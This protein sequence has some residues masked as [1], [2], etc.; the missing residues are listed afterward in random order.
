MSTLPDE[1]F[2]RLAL[3]A[4]HEAARQGSTAVAA[5]IAR[6]DEVLAVAGAAQSRTGNPTRHAEL[7][8]IDQACARVGREALVGAT[9]YSTMEP[10]P[11]CAWAIHLT[12]ITRVVLGARYHDVGRTDLH[13][14]S[15]EALM[16][17]SGGS[18]QVDSGV[19]LED[20]VAFRRDW[21]ARTG[22]I[23]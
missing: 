5:V 6:G 11:M 12:G 18:L 3:A 13:G 2:M 7:E 21:M 20:C 23:L 8:A 16:R 4:A 22:R 10:C 19:L 14:Y 17:L 9:L 15:V 1:H